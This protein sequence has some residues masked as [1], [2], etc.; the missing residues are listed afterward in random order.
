MRKLILCFLLLL[1]ISILQISTLPYRDNSVP[2][3]VSTYALG[4]PS[5]PR[6]EVSTVAKSVHLIA[7]NQLID[8][9]DNQNN[10]N[11]YNYLKELR[12]SGF[13]VF[14]EI[15]IIN[16]PGVRKGRSNLVNGWFGKAVSTNTF[17]KAIKTNQAIRDTILNKFS[18]V[19]TFAKQLEELGIEVVICPELEDNETDQTFN[20]LL[21]LLEKAGWVDNNGKLRVHKV[22]SNPM[23]GGNRVRLGIRKE[24]HSFDTNMSKLL[25]GDII[26][27]DG[28]PLE[29]AK[30]N[31]SNYDSGK[32][33]QQKLVA[34]GQRNLICYPW[35]AG[36]QGFKDYKNS[37]G[38]RV[39]YGSYFHRRYV[40]DYPDKLAA[41]LRFVYR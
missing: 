24:S 7:T 27:G 4:V 10:D 34:C 11:V 30:N 6:A 33:I 3:G 38:A 22:V 2:V 35:T 19:V 5:F 18:E 21:I 13:E 36:L 31:P 1:S 9:P 37:T 32:K 41:L 40:L 28:K 14:H 16:A 26:N 29:F 12:D 15:H 25:P 8:F 23:A 39:Y 20:I 17:V